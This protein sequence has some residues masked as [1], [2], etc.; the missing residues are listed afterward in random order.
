MWPFKKLRFES[1]EHA[2]AEASKYSSRNKWR[3]AYK[4]YTESLQLG[5][6]SLPGRDLARLYNERAF[7]ARCI[8]TELWNAGDRIGC[9]EWYAKAHEDY[10][11]AIKADASFWRPWFNKGNLLA[12]DERRFHEALPYLDKAAELNPAHAEIFNNM[13]LTHEALGNYDDA[14]CDFERAIGVDPKNAD[15]HSNIGTLFYEQGRYKEAAEWYE[16][17]TRLNPSDPDL[18]QNLEL[19]RSRF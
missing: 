10:D 19:A 16:K 18:W 12:R 3:R 7:M 17:A 13:G 6:K 2:I 4:V 1:V 8:G 9:D 5:N 11:S 15:A 14:L